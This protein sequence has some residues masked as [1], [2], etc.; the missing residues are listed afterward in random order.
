MATKIYILLS[1]VL[2][3]RCILDFF[4]GFINVVMLHLLYITW[5][6]GICTAFYNQT[7]FL[8]QKCVNIHSKQN[9]DSKY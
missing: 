4:S 7:I 2:G 8:Q 6:P 1:K 3:T 9:K 5:Y